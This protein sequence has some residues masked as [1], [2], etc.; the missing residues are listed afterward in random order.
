MWVGRIASDMRDELRILKYSPTT[1]GEEISSLAH[2]VGRHI[3]RRN[4]R[5]LFIIVTE[6]GTKV[7]NEAI[8]FLTDRSRA[9]NA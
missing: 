2:E 8:E 1:M 4:L 3:P 7:I 9:A 6:P 5:K